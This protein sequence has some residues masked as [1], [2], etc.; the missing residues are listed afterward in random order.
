MSEFFKDQPEF[1]EL[2][3]G[4]S[5]I[6]RT[7][8][9]ASFRELGPPDLCHVIKTTGRAGQ[10][11]VGSYHYVSGVD[12]SSSA[13]L[14][15]YI[16]SLTY[17]V[18]ET[19][20]WFFGSSAAKSGWRVR[21]GA[22]C[23]FNAFSRVDVRVEVKIPGGVEAYAIDVRGERHEAT[24]QMWQEVYLSAILRAILYADDPSYRLAGF[25]KLD[26]ITS[27]DAEMRFVAAA[28]AAF[29][30]GWQLGSE[31][32]VQVATVVSNHLATGLMKYFGDAARYGPLINLFEKLV[33][34][35]GEVACLLAQ[36]YLGMNEEVKAVRVLQSAIQQ[37][38]QSYSLL[39]VQCDFLRSKGR[40]E[41]AL[42][43]AKE[44][45]NC[46]PS[47]F[48]TWA[49]LTEVNMELGRYT[50]ALLTLNSCP[51]FTWAERDLH[52]MPT[53]AKSHLP[54]KEFI[55]SSG[56]LDD[57]NTS[58]HSSD[59]D[60][61][62]L[63]LPAPSLRGTFAKAY[64]LLA[65]LVSLVGWDELLKC[66][67]QV[68]VMEEEY[69]AHRAADGPSESPLVPNGGTESASGT[70]ETEGPGPL[71]LATDDEASEK[72]PSVKE[73]EEEEENQSEAVPSIPTIAVN[74]QTEDG[75][76]IDGDDSSAAEIPT[77]K[78]STES[79]GERE[80]EELKR[81]EESEAGRKA[82]EVVGKP[83]QA[84]QAS[85]EDGEAGS[86]AA[87]D[88]VATSEGKSSSSPTIQNKRL[89]ERWLDNLFMVL[90]EDLRIFTI[91]RAE[92]AHFKAQHLPYRK[93][94][95]EW[96][97]LGELAQRLHHREEAKDAF[98]RALDQKF[99]AKAWLKLLEI[100]VDEGDVQR[101][102][103]AAIRLSVYQHRWYMEQSYPTA[104]A[105]ELFKLIRRDGLAK[106][107]YSL[108]SMNIPQ[109]IL[110]TVMQPYFAYAQNFRGESFLSL[111]SLVLSC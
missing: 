9:L 53:P 60:V 70:D 21:G 20:S 18:E 1:I 107:S 2:D 28:E 62:L 37:H 12:A 31:P 105:K 100:Y 98:Q 44:A 104:V 90:Y 80:R 52:R 65:K 64:V 82:R 89:C 40:T 29:F 10:K 38:P 97:I 51:M 68:F 101:S 73:A 25:R 3:L 96:E 109:P 86:N 103:N 8:T 33:V 72:A 110:K 45:V 27:L 85:E 49:K 74:G 61:A 76:Q 13:S 95:T 81:F 83:N 91:W 34:K 17:T 24:P 23:S 22:F 59:A 42:K 71:A 19:S 102:L 84:R 50:D 16:N 30:K 41:W 6:S 94:G 5:L 35:E 106:I 7:E 58:S 11:D 78:V 111:S 15:A 88:V 4:E 87:A 39:H 14:A 108:V 47:E 99:S 67:S 77:I 79:D 63:R 46:A 55:A 32:E 93:T 57:E 36:S 56:I 43:L 48:V 75:Q 66:R 26:P 54:I 69:R 92:V